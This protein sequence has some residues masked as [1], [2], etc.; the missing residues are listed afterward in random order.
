M[1]RTPKTNR[2]IERFN[3]TVLDEFF[4]GAFRKKFYKSV[5]VLQADLDQWL[6]HYNK[7]RP[8]GGYR[9]RGK[10]PLGYPHVFIILLDKIASCTVMQLLRLKG[11]CKTRQNL[12]FMRTR[13]KI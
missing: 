2:L 3:R 10:R 6:V 9:N 13:C 4:R 11:L 1:V 5:D 12:I 7:Q 8:H